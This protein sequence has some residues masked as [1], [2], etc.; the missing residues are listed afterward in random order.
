VGSLSGC[1]EVFYVCYTEFAQKSIT[2]PQS[3]ITF[4]IYPNFFKKTFKSIKINIFETN[5]LRDN[6]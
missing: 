4:F 5:I 2:T 6:A 1:P 3:K